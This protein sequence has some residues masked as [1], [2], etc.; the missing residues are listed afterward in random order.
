MQAARGRCP[1]RQAS[2]AAPQQHRP[3]HRGCEA[4]RA[5]ISTSLA[6]GVDARDRH[7]SNAR[8]LTGA[9]KADKSRASAARI[10]TRIG[11]SG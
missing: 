1:I 10:V 11:P 7:R 6:I 9:T 8:C 5:V 4:M 2:A 3:L